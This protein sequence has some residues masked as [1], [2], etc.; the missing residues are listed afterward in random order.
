MARIAIRLLGCLG[1]FLAGCGESGSVAE[2]A[3][4]PTADESVSTDS[5]A[6]KGSLKKAKART[7]TP[8][9]LSKTAPD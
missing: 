3:P 5:A 7:L 6:K 2:V 4:A 1:L 8:D 9:S